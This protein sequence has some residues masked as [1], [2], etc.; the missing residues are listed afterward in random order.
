MPELPEV[1]TV[2]RCLRRRLVGLEVRSV[3]LIFPPIV[4][5]AEQ[6]YSQ[7]F[8]G[9]RVLGLRRR[10]KMILLDFSGG[11]T[12][13]FH[14][15]MTGQLLFCP[16]SAPR[17]K[18]THLVVAFRP[19]VGELRFRDVRKF[20]FMRGVRTAGADRAPEIRELGPEPLTLDLPSFLDLLRN[21]RGRLKS[22]LLNQRRIAGIGNIYADE[23]LFESG[24]DPRMEV[25]RLSRRRLE[26]LW[27]SVH[28]VL[29]EAI[30]F[31]GTTVRDF[32]DG[33]G[34]EGLFQNRL[35]VYGREGEP[36]PRCRAP[37]RRIRI[38][39]RSAHFC[40]RCQRR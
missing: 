21:R 24:L 10:G 1:E 7:K 28:A 6:S 18:H 33:D 23:I 22:L 19:G 35:R 8:V 40:P 27:S 26:R 32:R 17:D 39:G 11:L 2:V 16:S 13:I 3:R 36:C 29:D 34:F 31:K 15:R 9:R 4:R 37:I 14:L 25:S 38:S 20:G 30:A 12:M 5:N